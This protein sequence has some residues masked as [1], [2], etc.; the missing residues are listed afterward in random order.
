M[1][2]V[3]PVAPVEPVAPLN[4]VEPVAPVGMFWR[5]VVC[6][7][8]IVDPLNSNVSERLF[9]TKFANSCNCKRFVKSGRVVLG[10][11]IV[12]SYMACVLPT[13]VDVP[14]PS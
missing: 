11:A 14:E 9:P 10:T 8:E 7:C 12:K 2:P 1:N 6:V 4:P 5:R 13:G 3:G